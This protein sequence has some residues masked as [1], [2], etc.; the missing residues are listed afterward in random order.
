MPG[1]SPFRRHFLGFWRGMV[2]FST[3]RLRFWHFWRRWPAGACIPSLFRGRVCSKMAQNAHTLT[4][5]EEGM[6]GGRGNNPT[7]LPG[8][9]PV[10]EGKREGLK[11]GTI[12]SK[13]IHEAARGSACRASCLSAR[14]LFQPFE[15]N[16]PRLF[17]TPRVKQNYWRDRP[18]L[19]GEHPCRGLTNI[20]SNGSRKR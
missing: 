11:V 20:Y 17:L 10:R 13:S 18:T 14:D 8:L 12:L 3:F 15:K 19:R 6:H 5:L 2:G 1:F 9:A 16:R 4:H 7:D